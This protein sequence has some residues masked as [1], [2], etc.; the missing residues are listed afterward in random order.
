LPEEDDLEYYVDDIEPNIPWADIAFHE[1]VNGIPWNPGTAWESWPYAKSAENFKQERFSH[2]YAERYWP[3]Y[4][5]QHEDS[6]W[7]EGEVPTYNRHGIRFDYGDL[8]NIVALMNND[9]LT[10]QAYLPI[11]FP[12]DTG[13]VHGERVPCTLGYHFFHR[14]GEMDITYYI[15]SCDFV[16][17]FRDDLYMSLRLLMWM[18]NKVNFDVKPGR[19]IF[20]CTSMHM[21]EHDKR[22]I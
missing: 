10:R 14:Y 7:R 6:R 11:F 9:P 20:H 18:C 8:D 2:S 1:R 19:F 16:R 5:N 12:E 15:R 22:S 17:H 4:A 13:V 3:R 21:F